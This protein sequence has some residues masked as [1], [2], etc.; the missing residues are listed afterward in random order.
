M[1]PGGDFYWVNKTF[2][3]DNGVSR[4]E[5]HGHNIIAVDF[6]FTQDPTNLEAP[7]GNYK[8]SDLGCNSCH[9]PH[10][11]VQGGTEKGASPVAGTGSYGGVPPSGRILGNYRL[12]GDSKYDGG[13]QA[14]GYAFARNAPIARQDPN[15]RYGETNASHVDYGSGMS[16]WCGNCHPGFLVNNHSAFQHPSGSGAQLQTEMVVNYNSYVRTGD[17]SGNESTS[18]LPLVPFERGVTDRSLL[19]PTST[20]GPD[21]RSNVMCLT[22]HRAHASAFPHSGRWDFSADFIV[23]S[24]PATGDIG[25]TGNDIL[26]SYYGRDVVSSFGSGQKKFCEKC[27]G[28]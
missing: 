11:K 22:C 10:G 5:R 17:L 13:S 25:V 19:D 3:W 24:H 20:K 21:S 26:Y 2:T 18:Y 15:R 27:H 8:G 4:G 23:N 1:S 7:G 28:Q 6:G 16:E 9:D 14:L 12:L